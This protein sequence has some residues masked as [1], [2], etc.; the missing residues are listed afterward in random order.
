VDDIAADDCIVSFAS[1]FVGCG[2]RPDGS[3]DLDD[4]DDVLVVAIFDVR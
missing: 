2:L 4:E 3:R 1:A